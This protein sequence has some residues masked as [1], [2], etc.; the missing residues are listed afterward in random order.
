[1][2]GVS[3]LCANCAHPNLMMEEKKTRLWSTGRFCMRD[4]A[5]KSSWTWACRCGASVY[6]IYSILSAWTKS[7]ING[8]QEFIISPL[9]WGFIYIYIYIWLR[10]GWWVV[11]SASHRNCCSASSS[12]VIMGR[13]VVRYILLYVFFVERGRERGCREGQSDSTCR[14]LTAVAT[15]NERA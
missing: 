1:M 9:R 3:K 5:H 7:I 15:I 11:R 12:A 2:E 6:S 13:V 4:S 10:G 8:R 14:Q